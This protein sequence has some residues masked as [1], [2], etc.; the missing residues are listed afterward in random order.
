MCFENYK[1]G[2]KKKGSKTTY[3]PMTKRKLKKCEPSFYSYERREEE[4]RA[5]KDK[6]AIHFSC[7]KRG[8]EGKGDIHVNGGSDEQW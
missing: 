6:P 1:N 4:K 2:Q 7:C 8:T 5:H 3:R